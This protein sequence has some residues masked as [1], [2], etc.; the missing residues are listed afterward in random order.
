MSGTLGETELDIGTLG[1]LIYAKF[2]FLIIDMF[3]KCSYVLEMQ[4]G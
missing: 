4:Q 2:S 3:C 1:K